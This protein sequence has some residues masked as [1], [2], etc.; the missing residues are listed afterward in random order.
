[1]AGPEKL[2][3]R[4][5]M[6]RKEEKKFKPALTALDFT[7]PTA[8]REWGQRCAVICAAFAT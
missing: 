6:Q 4:Y 5:T 2:T 1:M 8:V 3:G 7:V